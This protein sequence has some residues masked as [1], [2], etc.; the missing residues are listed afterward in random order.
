MRMTFEWGVQQE[1]TQ[2]RHQA[3]EAGQDIESESQ[4]QQA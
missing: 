3:D 4:V 1:I 2:Q